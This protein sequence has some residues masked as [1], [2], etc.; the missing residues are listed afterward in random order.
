MSLHTVDAEVLSRL[1]S[2]ELKLD[3]IISAQNPDVLNVREAAQFLSISVPTVRSWIRDRK[4]PVYRVGNGIRFKR[5]DLE[6]VLYSDRS[7][8]ARELEAIA[9][10]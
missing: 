8:S 1:A 10:G 9:R 7:R 3:K 2:V 5:A 4:L 6:K